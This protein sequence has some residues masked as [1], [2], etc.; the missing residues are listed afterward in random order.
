MV[1]FDSVTINEDERDR[2]PIAHPVRDEEELERAVEQMSSVEDEN[3]ESEV[4]ALR[5]NLD[6][7]VR[8]RV[9][10]HNT[11]IGLMN[12]PTVNEVEVDGEDY[13][14]VGERFF[15][16]NQFPEFG[17]VGEIRW[18]A[19]APQDSW[20]METPINRGE[21][22]VGRGRQIE[23]YQVTLD[24]EPLNPGEVEALSQD[25]RI[26]QET[27][28]DFTLDAPRII[29]EYDSLTEAVE[30]E[31]IT[32]EEF[33]NELRS[34]QHRGMVTEDLDITLKGW[35]SFIDTNAR[36]IAALEQLDGSQ[37]TVDLGGFRPSYVP[38]FGNLEGAVT[39]SG[40]L[41]SAIFSN[42]DA[43]FAT[44]SDAEV[45]YIEG[46]LD[47]ENDAYRE[48]LEAIMGDLESVNLHD[49]PGGRIGL[50][51]ALGVFIEGY[52]GGEAVSIGED[53]ERGSDE[54]DYLHELIDEGLAGIE[55]S[56]L[57][58]I[59]ISLDEELEQEL[60]EM[61]YSV[62][63]I[64]QRLEEASQGLTAAEDDG[65]MFGGGDY[66]LN[67]EGL[68]DP[69][70]EIFATEL[71]ELNRRQVNPDEDRDMDGSAIMVPNLML[72]EY[73]DELETHGFDWDMVS[74]YR[75]DGDD[76]FFGADIEAQFEEEREDLWGDVDYYGHEDI[77]QEGNIRSPKEMSQEVRGLLRAMEDEDIIQIDQKQIPDTV[78]LHVDTSNDH[79]EP[80]QEALPD[81]GESFE[82]GEATYEVGP[83]E[84]QADS[85]LLTVMQ[86]NEA[87]EDYEIDETEE[88]ELEYNREAMAMFDYEID[89]SIDSVRIADEPVVLASLYA[90]EEMEYES[91]EE[92]ERASE[93]MRPFNGENIPYDSDR[94]TF[95]TEFQLD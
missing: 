37:E 43:L 63:E 75:P 18:T 90:T 62:E 52:D 91:N 26:S 29:A 36:G 20:G 42:G 94:A 7:F 2:D 80:L 54:E 48:E 46:V 85:L 78:K 72:V 11:H 77:Y 53:V 8:R 39:S 14:V 50:R 19:L 58:D 67:Y 74:T 71:E 25:V 68:D 49:Q 95:E 10:N 56:N 33:E 92:L 6:E 38:P 3:F 32:Q 69:L 65:F 16:M 70:Y 27:E 41:S 59:T 86:D 45:D 51:D 34:A 93:A 24:G 44:G 28:Q 1:E 76:E 60:Q 73:M 57:E 31:N 30:S 22:A 87:V 13:Q 55:E 79:Y 88:W 81:S 12:N 17:D 9:G 5:N 61:G 35:M 47:V 83:G 4:L 15:E 21:H 66:S 89:A 82:N 64:E 23:A 40:R 84:N